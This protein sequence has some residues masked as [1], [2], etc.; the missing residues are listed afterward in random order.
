MRNGRARE[1]PNLTVH[2]VLFIVTR[3]RLR[4]D[5]P[6]DVHTTT[7]TVGDDGFM[8]TALGHC[9]KAATL[10]A[11]G[12]ECVYSTPFKWR[13]ARLKRWWHV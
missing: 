3:N 11:L 4:S 7:N 10:Y 1:T 12:L 13:W 9:H 6:R 2:R 8:A 5:R